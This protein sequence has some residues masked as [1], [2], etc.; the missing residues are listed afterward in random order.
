[1]RLAV[2]ALSERAPAIALLGEGQH[3][4]AE[5]DGSRVQLRREGGRLRVLDSPQAG[6][7]RV[8]SPSRAMAEAETTLLRRG[9]DD[10]DLMRLRERIEAAPV[11]VR[12][13]VAP[14]LAVRHGQIREAYPDLRQPLAPDECYLSIAFLY[15]ALILGKTIYSAGFD[16]IRRALTGRPATGWSVAPMMARSTYEPFHGLAIE[17][18]S[19]GL[20]V[21]LRL[22]GC[23]A[24]LVT[25]AGLQLP[26]GFSPPFYRLDLEAGEES[27]VAASEPTAS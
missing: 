1:M 16:P 24:W 4:F 10:A 12:T 26:N 17:S 22:F 7:S 25:I 13:D 5:A 14:G 15:L 2:E 9:A 27:L 3:F 20:T 18:N 6:G 23:L 11:G 8:K 19:A 21:Q